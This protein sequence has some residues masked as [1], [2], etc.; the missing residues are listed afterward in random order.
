MSSNGEIMIQTVD[1]SKRY[2]DGVLAL[3][4]LNIEVRAGEIY[5]MLG[6]NGAG[7]T[8]TIHLFLNFIEPTS[9]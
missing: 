4:R 8:T 9:G 7:K 3:D 2:D 5:A 6:G 1:L